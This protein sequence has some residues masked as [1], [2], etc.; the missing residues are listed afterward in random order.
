MIA[1]EGIDALIRA[2]WSIFDNQSTA[3]AF[4]AWRRQALTAMTALV[5]KNHAY[6]LYVEENVQPG[7]RGSLL[8]AI[9]LLTAVGGRAGIRSRGKDWPNV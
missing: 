7:S 8:I 6:T 3:T 5:G 9:G 2:G 1:D 4:E